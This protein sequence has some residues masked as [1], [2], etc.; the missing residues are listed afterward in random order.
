MRYTVI[1]PTKDRYGETI[2]EGLRKAVFEDTIR[3]IIEETGGVTT[4]EGEGHWVNEIG[5]LISEPVTKIE[6]YSE[7]EHF[8]VTLE[9]IANRVK[10]QLNQESVM[11]TV[12]GKGKFV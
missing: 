1:I 3:A 8:S 7:K 4:I 11:Y 6:T 2:K 5:R 10:E 9:V 12:G